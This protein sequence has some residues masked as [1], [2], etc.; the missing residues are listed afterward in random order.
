MKTS[1][2]RRALRLPRRLPIRIQITVLTGLLIAAI[3]GFMYAFFPAR[4]EK[5][6]FNATRDRTN[7]MAKVEA[8][9]VAP[10][11]YFSDAT[12]V[13]D[14]LRALKANILLRYVTVTDIKGLDIAEIY[15]TNAD[16][17]RPNRRTETGLS[18]DGELYVSEAK[19]EHNG[20]IIGTV[21]L[22][23]SLT[24][25]RE[26]VATARKMIALV[27]LVVF[28][29]G[30]VAVYAIGVLVTAPV[31][32]IATTAR[33]VAAGDATQRVQGE[34]Y[35]EVGQV[36]VAINGMLDNLHAAQLELQQSNHSLEDRVTA[37]TA[38][39]MASKE[40]LEISRDAAEAASRAK[41]E[42]LANM[43]HEIR[44]PMNGVIG[45]IELSLDTEL[46][47]QQADYL[48]VAKSS[49]DA[50]LV[51]I[52]D[53]LDFS[54]IEARMMEI[55]ASDFNI[56]ELLDTTIQGLGARADAKGLELMHT[57]EPDVPSMVIGDAGRIR[58]VIVNLVGNAI[59]FTQHGEVEVRLALEGREE[60]R[61]VLHGS[62]RDTGI[63]IPA[64]K[65]AA[66]FTAFSQADGS[67]TRV[68]GGTGLG[69][70]ISSQLVGLMQG[71][72][73]V[74]SEPGLGST[75]HFT[76]ELGVS[77][78]AA[79]ADFPV[80]DLKGLRVLVVDDNATNRKILGE[81]LGKWGILSVEVDGGLAALGLL[82]SADTNPFDLIIVDGHMPGIDGYDLAER[83]RALPG[84]NDAL[85]MMLTSRADSG[86]R[87]RCQKMGIT[88]VLTKPVIRPE[89]LQ[90]ILAVMKGGP[91]VITAP[92]RA[93]VELTKRALQILLA[94]DNPVN[95][96]VASAVLTKRGH[97]VQV[98]HNGQEAF[99]AYRL[100]QFD[101]ILMDVQ[102]PVMG[103]F[104]ATAAIRTAEKIAGGHI[105]IVA[106]TAHA[107][108]GDKELCMAA[109]MDG[110]VTKPF[111]AMLLIQE[112]E[113]LAGQR[114]F[115]PVV[116][117]EAVVPA[118]L[119]DDDLL[120]RFMGD[121]EL[122][123]GVAETFLESEAMLRT[124]L[125]RGLARNDGAEVVRT[126]H[127]LKGSV[128]NFG[129]DT[130]M[131]LAGKIE[132]LGRENQVA[133][134]GKIFELLT[135]ELDDLR[136][137]LARVVHTYRAPV[138]G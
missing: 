3:A 116:P 50:L 100:G 89:L 111:R 118:D 46:T 54:K 66:V 4:L 21:R 88:S 75:F 65:Q 25:M 51:V 33:L 39:L 134:A 108:K 97:L 44:T 34:V 93:T 71:R 80:A 69:L 115:E 85:I 129:A 41:S 35:G 47:R 87:T 15:T 138:I 42:F 92:K 81:T 36:A 94:E 104:E 1:W 27:S 63:G 126:A 95:Q 119:N 91:R 2:A 60:E 109:G 17:Q 45:M 106:L 43:S 135:G 124:Q 77:K 73:W 29:G 121:T 48:A 59:K 7:S 10:A 9:T 99:D 107:M 127:S 122:L 105:P 49:A 58:Q 62:V 78:I 110:Y 12:A 22:A 117:K 114:M 18:A 64:D 136:V 55:D 40:A 32:A 68:Y 52:N 13:N 90:A 84:R 76:L 16:A 98:A 53:I 23:F 101:L 72:L 132:V 61:M 5:Q 128:G 26:E 79:P 8:Y 86:Q 103:G 67:T 20:A 120:E 31:T 37:R 96:L 19:I 82:R 38:E 56:R 113:R 102:M 131:E 28:L 6:A 123:C 74:Q 11:L 14:G 70:T 133:Q 112:V 83:I 24:P 137:Q 125:A 30:L 130:A 57:I